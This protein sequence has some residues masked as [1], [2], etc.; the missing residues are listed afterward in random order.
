MHLQK[1]QSW[2]KQIY[3]FMFNYHMCG[4]FI[5]SAYIL[6][7]SFEVEYGKF[8]GLC[9]QGGPK[10]RN[11]PKNSKL[12]RRPI[13]QRPKSLSSSHFP[14]TTFGPFSISGRRFKV[15]LGSFWGFCSISNSI[16]MSHLPNFEL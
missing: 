13:S 4:G 5:I 2:K 12:T 8:H 6:S 10:P 7:S 1:C 15:F 11:Y 9:I 16:A 3:Y 14:R